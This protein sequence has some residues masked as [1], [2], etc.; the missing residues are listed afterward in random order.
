VT[1]H[2]IHAVSDQPIARA[3]F[4]ARQ[5]EENAR[6]RG[7][8][9]LSRLKRRAFWA[10]LGST[11]KLLLYA[12]AYDH[13]TIDPERPGLVVET[14]CKTIIVELGLIPTS[15][16]RPIDSLIKAG[17]ISRLEA[18]GNRPTRHYVHWVEPSAEEEII[19]ANRLAAQAIEQ[20]PRVGGAPNCAR[21]S[22]GAPNCARLSSEI[23][24]DSD[25]CGANKSLTDED[26]AVRQNAL[27]LDSDTLIETKPR[28]QPENAGVAGQARAVGG[29]CPPM[30]VCHDDDDHTYMAENQPVE[31]GDDPSEVYVILR[32]CGI[33]ETV[34]RRNSVAMTLVD[35][36]A[37]RIMQKRM[38]RLTNPGGWANK[39]IQLREISDD[40]RAEARRALAARAA[41]GG[42][43]PA[44]APESAFHRSQREAAAIEAAD[45]RL[46]AIV[47]SLP[48][49]RLA[50]LAAA[51]LAKYAGNVA[52][53]SVLK[54]K[55]PRECRLMKMEIAAILETEA[56]HA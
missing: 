45:R 35:A 54:R 18:C 7:A 49:D 10:S 32:E 50:S 31:A 1:P 38:K 51:V 52:M 47:A 22:G 41:G 23:S 24:L 9:I 16:Y 21:L 6:A 28:F 42:A 27:S 37:L 15:A 36:M 4:D 8:V 5:P 13:G 33:D 46:D 2:Y 20:A 44:P 55:P 3:T 25:T 14:S 17:V 53:T 19:D 29:A 39:R 30:H 26:L 11:A 48:E 40:A 56:A 34:A 43:A 12:M